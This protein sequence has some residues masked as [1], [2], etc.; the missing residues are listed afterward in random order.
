MPHWIYWAAGIALADALLLYWN[1]RSHRPWG[2]EQGRS[3]ANL[4]AEPNRGLR[5]APTYMEM[6]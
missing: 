1:Y 2:D 6:P 4:G 3:R 5:Q